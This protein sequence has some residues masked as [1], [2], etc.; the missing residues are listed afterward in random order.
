MWA[1]RGEILPDDHGGKNEIVD[2]VSLS[3]F[4]AFLPIPLS[5]NVFGPL[6]TVPN[7]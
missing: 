1:K 5:S 3:L 2:G 6:V 4:L 7:V